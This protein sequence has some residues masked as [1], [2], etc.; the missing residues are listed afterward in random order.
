ARQLPDRPPRGARGG[1]GGQ[2]P[3]RLPREVRASRAAAAGV[4]GCRHRRRRRPGLRR[5]PHLRS[6]G[7]HLRGPGA[8][9]RRA[10]DH[11]RRLR[12]LDDL[13]DGRRRSRAVRPAARADR[14]RGRGGPLVAHRRRPAGRRPRGPGDG[15]VPLGGDAGRGP[16]HGRHRHPAA[17]RRPGHR[18]RRRAG[19]PDVPRGHPDQPDPLLHLDRRVPRRRGR[20]R[21]RLRGARPAGGP[22]P[23]R[24]GHPGLRRLP[25]HPAHLLVR[26]AAQGRLQ[27]LP[28]DDRPRGGRLGALRR[29]D[30]G[31][32]PAHDLRPDRCAHRS[33][34]RA[35][36][37]HHRKDPTV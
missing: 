16:R 13:L 15:A 12:H 1:P 14:P 5:R 23:A 10:V 3:G 2:H 4:G 9:R 7:A 25:R 33:G 35:R 30:H 34:G 20:R 6:E 8:D 19:L 29:P 36:P 37:R 26:D 21:P 31:A 32:V 17:R 22:L 28:R 11:R 27:L 18:R 24:A